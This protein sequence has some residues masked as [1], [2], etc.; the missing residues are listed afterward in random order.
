M[1]NLECD[2]VARYIERLATDIDH[3]SQEADFDER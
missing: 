2:L 3:H 1:V